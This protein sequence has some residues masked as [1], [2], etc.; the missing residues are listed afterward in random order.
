MRVSLGVLGRI[1]TNCISNNMR[2]GKSYE[3]GAKNPASVLGACSVFTSSAVLCDSVQ[4][5]QCGLLLT[6]Y[7]LKK[8]NLKVFSLY[9]LTYMYQKATK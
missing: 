4:G 3:S 7:N 9:L 2:N 1:N 8:K 6:Q 5:S